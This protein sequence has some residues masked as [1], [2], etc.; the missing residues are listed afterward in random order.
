MTQNDLE[1]LNIKPDTENLIATIQDAFNN[2]PFKISL[3]TKLGKVG[4]VLTGQAS[5]NGNTGLSEDM[6]TLVNELGESEGL[7]RDGKLTEIPGGMHIENL[8][9]GDVILNTRQMEELKKSG[10]ASG[11]G[12]IV[13]GENSLTA[14]AG[15]TKL[16][17]F[18]SRQGR[19]ALYDSNGIKITGLES[20]DLFQTKLDR[21]TSAI[22][23]LADS[24]NEYQTLYQRNNILTREQNKILEQADI[25]QRQADMYNKMAKDSIGYSWYDENNEKQNANL[26][27]QLKNYGF[28]SL[29]DLVAGSNRLFQI[30]ATT[31]ESQ[32]FV[33]AANNYIQLTTQAQNASDAIFD[34]N[35]QL[36][37]IASSEI[38]APFEKMEQN[39]KKL[40]RQMEVFS[41]FSETAGK[42]EATA[43]A[44]N[45]ILGDVFGEEARNMFDSSGKS[46]EILNREIEK[47]IEY[48]KEQI[49]QEKNAAEQS[50]DKI[51]EYESANNTNY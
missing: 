41:K 21:N 51:K 31:K 27:D 14:L 29:E 30:D 22:N 44:L 49:N 16:T 26:L 23:K 37:D 33:N 38:S 47:N 48:T 39:L 12:K 5:V 6:P 46:Y 15:G 20:F 40:N 17:A 7:I 36:A 34:L 10:K 8:K 18:A 9:K 45:K 25:Y 28:A 24:L 4:E 13:G 3:M 1:L 50:L 43:R 2:N 32:A 35:K 19:D 11:K 42:G